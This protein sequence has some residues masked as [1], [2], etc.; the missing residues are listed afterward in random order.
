MKLLKKLTYLS[1]GAVTVFSVASCQ[2]NSITN[3]ADSDT[4]N[5][6]STD[7]SNELR[8]IKTDGQLDN[9][10]KQNMIKAEYLI[11][12]NGYKDSDEI[13][14]IITMEDESLLDLYNQYGTRYSSVSEFYNSSLGSSKNSTIIYKQNKLID[15]LYSKGLIKEVNQT[16][17]TILNGF[18]VRTTYGALSELENISNISNTII[19]DTYNLPTSTTSSQNGVVNNVVDVYDTGIF[20]SSKVDYDGNGTSVA[21][22]D[23]GFDV[24]HSVFST[25][26]SKEMFTLEDVRNKLTSLNAYKT[27]A[28]LKAEDVYYSKKI[29]YMYDYAD[30]DYDVNPTDS[31][32]GTHVAGII[33]GHDDTITGVAVNTQL[34]LMKVFG[35]K[36]SGAETDDLLA[37]LNDA[38]VLGVDCINMS[39]GT[40]CGF[41]READNDAINET[42]DAVANAGISLLAAASNDYSAGMGGPDGNTN[43]VTNPDSGTLGSPASYTSSLSVASISGNMSSYIVANKDTADES[44]FYFLQSRTITSEANDFVSELENRDEEL[45]TN[46]TKTYEYVT[47]PGTGSSASYASINVTGKIALVKRGDSSFDDKVKYAQRKGAVAI[48]V[49]NNVEGDISMTISLTDHIPAISISKEDGLKLAS[50]SSG[51]I[52]ISTSYKAGPFMSDFSSWG[53]TP[54]LEIKPEITAHGGEILSSIPGGG[55]DKMSGTSMATPNMCG[56][57]VLIKQYL[58]EKYPS[59]NAKEI[60]ELAYALLM[61]TA[62]IANNEQGNPYTP[63]K[64]GAGL[65]NI[66]S[67]TTSNGYISV[68]GSDK[69][70]L[71]LG[72]DAKRTGVYEMTFTINNL[73]DKALSYSLDLDVMTESVSSS[74]SDFVAEKSYMLDNTF[75]AYVS[76]TKLVNKIV[77]VPAN[78]S[79]DVTYKYTLTDE[80]KAYMNEAFPYGIYVEGYAKANA[81]SEGESDLNVPFLAFYGDWTEAPL[82]DKTYFEVETTAHNANIDDDDKVKAD[83]WATRPYASYMYNYIVPLGTYIYD[84]DET[85]YQAIPGSVDHIAVG[86]SNG[87]LEGISVVYAGCLRAAKTMTYTITDTVTGEVL[88]EYVDYNCSKAFGNNGSAMPYY[89]YIRQTASSL[90]L[91]N[92]RK[93]TFNMVGTLDYGD[94]G[95]TTNVRNSFGFDFTMDN[96]API[97]K[98]ATFESEYDETSKKTHYYVTLTVSDNH[99]VQAVTPVS[100]FSKTEDG[101]TTNTYTTLS[102]P[103]PVYGEKG[104]DSKVRVEITDYMDSLSSNSIA[105]NCLFFNIDDYALNANI[106]AVELPGTTSAFSFKADGDINAENQTAV[107]ISIGESYDLYKLLASTEETDKSYYKYLN[108]ESSKSSVVSVKDGVIYGLKSGTATITCTDKVRGNS[109]TIQVSVKRSTSNS[110]LKTQLDTNA[111]NIDKISFDY[112]DTVFA[113]ANSGDTSAIGTT[114]DRLYVTNISSPAMYPGEKIKL[115]ANLTP[116]YADFA[117]TE[118]T[119]TNDKICSVDENGVVTALKEGSATIS[120]KKKNSTISAMIKITVNSEFVI[121]SRTLTAYKG[122]GGDVVIPADKG[123][124]Y[125]GAYAFSLYTT[126]RTVENP[127]DDDD[128][129]KT[130]STNTTIKSVVIPDGVE[131]IKKYAFYNCTGLESVT[132]PSSVKYIREYAFSFNSALTDSTGHKIK[133]SLTNVNLSNVEVIGENAFAY[134]TGL[135]SVSL[136]KCYAISDYAFRGC[137]GLTSVDISKLRNSGI[138]VFKDCTNLTSYTTDPNGQTR[139]GE[140]MFYNSGLTSASVNS[141]QIPARAFS[142]CAALSSVVV[143][144]SVVTIGEEAFANNPKLTTITINGTVEYLNDL[145]LA[146]NKSLTEITLPNSSVKISG[147]PL[148]NNPELTTLKFQANTYL[149][150]IESGF[151]LGSKISTFT[152]ANGSKY[153]VNNNLLCEGSKVILAAPNYEYGDFTIPSEINVIGRGAFSG[154]DKITSLV[155]PSSVTLEAYAFAN[156]SN[157]ASVTFPESSYSIPE[158]A[159]YNAKNLSTLNNVS[160]LSSIGAYAFYKLSSN[161]T[162]EL[163]LGSEVTINE[164]AFEGANINKFTLGENTTIGNGAFKNS[165]AIQNVVLSSNTRIEDYAFDNTYNLNTINLD[166]VT[167]IGSYAFRGCRNLTTA[168]LENAEYIGSYA[169]A[170]AKNLETVTAPKVTYI[171]SYAFSKSNDDSTA[172]KISSFVIPNTVTYIGS[173]AFAYSSIENVTIP[174]GITS[175]SDYAFAYATSLSNVVLNSSVTSIGAYAFAGDTNLASINLENIKSVSTGAFAGSSKLTSV[176]LSNVETI[177]EGAFANSAIT[178]NINAPKL[179]NIDSYAFQGTPITGL[180]ALNLVSIKDG[181]LYG[182]KITKFSVS[183]KIS[184]IGQNVFFDANELTEFN[185]VLNNETKTSGKINEYAFVSDGVLYTY[186][187]KHKYKLVAVPAN[188]NIETLNVVEGTSYIDIFAGNANKN[189][190]NIVLPDSLRTIGAFAF[191][192]V[193]N[194]KSVEFKSVNAPKVESYLLDTLYK[195]VSSN[196]TTQNVLLIASDPGYEKIHRYYDVWQEDLYYANFIDLIGRNNPISIILPNNKDLSG[197]DTVFYDVYFDLANKT[198]SNYTAMDSYA[199]SYLENVELIMNKS[200]ITLQ[201]ESLVSNCSMAYSNMSTDLKQFGYT[202]EEIDEMFIAYIKAKDTIHELKYKT[203]SNEIKALQE[204]INNLDTAFT[205]SRLSELQE[206][207]SEL[208]KL[209]LSDKAILDLTNYETLQASYNAYL[210]TL[211]SSINSVNGVVNSTFNYKL[212]V[213]SLLLSSISLV[214]VCGILFKHF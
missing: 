30:K 124:L 144:G 10:S 179:T 177:G 213:A 92:N 15:S 127:T 138:G 78:G 214:S 106:Y 154:I 84:L 71:E 165:S 136:N 23:S 80:A 152:V 66:T 169:F 51:T 12:N 209:S 151:I 79:V 93:Y 190:K 173:Y 72:D 189:I 203:A 207:A 160:Y 112:F 34:V 139:L 18:S 31:S 198:I 89:N 103:I 181:A 19:C 172:P 115:H 99:Y 101:K 182:T 27:T 48:V 32:H 129:N 184:Y 159:F 110:I 197:Y 143:N 3:K 95:L 43:K 22:L 105:S 50:K 58:K 157:L 149:N 211:D 24:S 38:V 191:Y 57:V 69:P 7:S 141:T 59:K 90:G 185:Y 29:P 1:L 121:E 133:S 41:N 200:I 206:L 188:K 131:D 40:S 148:S 162:I 117:D 4:N 85:K 17:T 28:N 81:L 45:K 212:V 168:N 146:N 128:Y 35:D 142:N 166:N 70:K 91:V 155:I 134:C 199:V 5:N 100:F 109:A 171:G 39:L 135:T 11:K 2:S 13:D 132:I 130:P 111:A 97:I 167:Y 64:Q 33:G 186:I 113:Y 104:S 161:K 205:I 46:G 116:Y 62:T 118:W 87:T 73:S 195:S 8:V 140:E 192:Q 202:Q 147:S 88:W 108:W 183:D 164:S 61:S 156:C 175:I 120:L 20:N 77:T 94:G 114:G 150:N 9:A 193:S 36:S 153:T 102:N 49:Y 26:P 107:S 137:T 83:Y 180:T 201:D 44:N 42:Y 6:S 158:Y 86:D 21:V 204:K 176:D 68:K 74:D 119:S 145:A 37:A 67:A 25:E 52:T 98:G 178:T 75:E 56:V 63:R 65:A 82:F 54:S 208:D 123:I 76:G 194:L 96:E 163:T 210:A 125:I 60:Q 174:Q 14:V 196:G 55:Y 16:Y 53:P 47:V 126:D 187:T 122:L 170:N